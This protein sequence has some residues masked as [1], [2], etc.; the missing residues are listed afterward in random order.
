[1]NLF[2][3]SRLEKLHIQAI[4]N[5]RQIPGLELLFQKLLDETKT[6]L[7]TADDTDVVRRLQGRAKVLDDFLEAMKDAPSVL[8]RL[9]K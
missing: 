1:M 7:I 2:L 6:A 4:L 5:C 3:G 9:Q 8:E